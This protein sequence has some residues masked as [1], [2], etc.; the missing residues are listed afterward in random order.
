M[1]STLFMLLFLQITNYSLVQL[2]ISKCRSEKEKRRLFC[3]V[4]KCC[5]L[6]SNMSWLAFS[7]ASRATLVCNLPY[8]NSH[9]N[10]VLKTTYPSPTRQNIVRDHIQQSVSN[11]MLFNRQYYKKANN[12]KYGSV[13]TYSITW[14]GTLVSLV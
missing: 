12:S 11:R 1:V 8:S 5:N 9:K 2:V 3:F 14:G 6:A 10:Q 13:A 4:S 7:S